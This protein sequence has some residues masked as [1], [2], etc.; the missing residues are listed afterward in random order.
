MWDGDGLPMEPEV[1]NQ[2]RNV[3]SLPVVVGAALMADGHVGVG[4][5][6][7]RRGHAGGGRPSGDR[8]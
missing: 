4:P 5:G 8:C 2:M 7:R 3:A 6:R 1:F